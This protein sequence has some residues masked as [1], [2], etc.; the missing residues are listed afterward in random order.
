MEVT[1]LYVDV[2]NLHD[3]AQHAIISAIAQW[4]TEFPKIE[5]LQL[6]VTADQ[7]QLWNMWATH[8]FPTVRICV[9]G[10]QRYG[11]AS[12]NLADM[13]L[14]L[15]ALA[16]LLKSRTTHVAVLSDDSDY[17]VLFAAINHEMPSDSRNKVPFAWF[18]TDRPDT[19]T[20]NL[21]NFLPSGYIH[22]VPCAAKLKPKSATVKKSVPNG[23]AQSVDEVI[24]KAIIR[25]I[26]IGTFKNADCMNIV[27]KHF[28]EDSLAHEDSA[29]FGLHFAKRVSPILQSYGVKLLKGRNPRKYEITEE[30]K[31]KVA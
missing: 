31:K 19:H 1:T 26:P 11:S 10:V 8:Q 29:K 25:E 12:K 9:K 17:V 24:A 22:V 13:S 27:K 14:I 6:Y 7:S 21:N 2:E 18:L 30:A 15:D 28:P 5:A 16:D 23:V 3:V 20:S 4:P